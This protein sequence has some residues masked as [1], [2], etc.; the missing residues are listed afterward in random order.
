MEEVHI[1]E[2]IIEAIKAFVNGFS[3][4]TIVDAYAKINFDQIKLAALS[5][6]E[7]LEKIIESL[8]A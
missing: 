8:A 6:F 1:M 2:I 7:A 3:I 5:I 4:D